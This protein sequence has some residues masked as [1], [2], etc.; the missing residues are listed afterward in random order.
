MLSFRDGSQ[1]PIYLTGDTVWFDGV[2][3]V[4]RRFHAG[5]VLP[6]AGAARTRGPFDLT[7]DTNDVVETA[8]AFPD[9]I[10]VPVHLDSWAH[11]TQ[12]RDD[13][14]ATFRALGI[15]DRLRLLEPG[16][17]TPIGA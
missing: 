1:A 5:V 17:P 3:E 8:R 10:I 14:R 15:S 16:I 13:L 7:M 9:A 4:A 12:H 2:A 6:F 11:F